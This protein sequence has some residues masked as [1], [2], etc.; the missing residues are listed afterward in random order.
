MGRPRLPIVAHLPHDEVARRYRACRDGR[1]KTHW[2]LIWL[3]TRS[4]R[5]LAPAEAA[6]RVGLTP[7][8]ART[9]LK[10]WNAEGPPDRPTAAGRPTAASPS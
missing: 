5:P 1:E 7:S 3:L 6:E 10:R 8:W 4:D 2:Q 9:I